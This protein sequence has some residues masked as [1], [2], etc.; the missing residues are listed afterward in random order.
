MTTYRE[1]VNMILDM[2]KVISDDSIIQQ[3]HVI[4]LLDKYRAFLLKQ[5]YDD[6]RKSMSQSNKQTICLDLEPYSAF[7]NDICNNNVQLRSIQEVPFMLDLDTPKVTTM[8]QFGNEISYVG[9]DRYK[10][11]GNSKYLKNTL[12][13]TLGSD[14]HLYVK[15]NN[16]QFLHLKRVKVTGIF[17]DS[18]KAA[19]LSCDGNDDQKCD[20]LDKNF[21]IEEA[22]IPYMIAL[23]VKDLI[24]MAYRPA[25]NINNASDDLSDLMTYLRR[26][27]KTPLQKQLLNDNSDVLQELQGS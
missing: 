16:S 8:D 3:E 15:A 24:G 5:K 26:N 19:E 1:L 9:I 6:V 2:V 4:F 7:D 23:I 25:D 20:V 17:E 14:Q 21:P 13:S 22:F 10:Y 12:Y 11:V 27:A 18:S